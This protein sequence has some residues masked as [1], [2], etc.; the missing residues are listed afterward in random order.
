[1]KKDEAKGDMCDAH[2]HPRIDFAM[3]VGEKERKGSYTYWLITHNSHKE[4][5]GMFCAKDFTTQSL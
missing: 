4:V 3:G 5:A 1:V 2:G